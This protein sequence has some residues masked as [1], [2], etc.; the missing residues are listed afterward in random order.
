M[1]HLE[2]LRSHLFIEGGNTSPPG[3]VGQSQ[4]GDNHCYLTAA[5]GESAEQAEFSH[6]RYHLSSA[7]PGNFVSSGSVQPSL[8]I[9][10]L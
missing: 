1:G 5:P 2:S 10:D 7:S 3:A 4:E 8:N 6:P 9:S